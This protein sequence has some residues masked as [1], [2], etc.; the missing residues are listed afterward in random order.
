MVFNYRAKRPRAEAVAEQ[1]RALGRHALFVQADTT[2]PEDVERMMRETAAVGAL[3]VL[4]LNA[5]GGLEK[6]Q[7][8]DYAL[9][10]NCD[11]QVDLAERALPL[12]SGGGRIVF[13]IALPAFNA[14]E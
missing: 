1:V 10:L 11:A 13:V 7:T 4:V 2:V 6:N 5:S 9:R 3:N 14:P 12:M 8:P